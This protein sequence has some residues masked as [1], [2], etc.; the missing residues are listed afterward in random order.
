MA[1]PKKDPS[2]VIG[3]PLDKIKIVEKILGRE[4]AN[5]QKA[6]LYVL[7]LAVFLLL[8]AITQLSTL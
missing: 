7:L 3:I 4:V 6:L 1:R 2:E 8:N 5:N